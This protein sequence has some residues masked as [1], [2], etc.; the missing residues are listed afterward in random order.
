MCTCSRA[1]VTD[2]FVP[3]LIVLIMWLVRG[4]GSPWWLTL[5]SPWRQKS[6]FHL[7]AEENHKTPARQFSPI[8]RQ[9][10]SE[11]ND[12]EMTNVCVFWQL[13]CSPGT[14]SDSTGSGSGLW[15]GYSKYT[16]VSLVTNVSIL[17]VTEAESVWWSFSGDL[18]SS[19][20]EEQK[21]SCQ[22]WDHER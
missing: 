5:G 7:W 6:V 18:C 12:D 9:R 22:G 1:T 21:G 2:V 4:P 8:K 19:R 14:G 3:M 16:F 10:S 15:T 11:M 17:T 20:R 13:P